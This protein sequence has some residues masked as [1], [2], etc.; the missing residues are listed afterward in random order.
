MTCPQRRDGYRDAPAG[1][2]LHV[3]DQACL[4]ID[5]GRVQLAGVGGAERADPVRA[6]RRLG[7]GAQGDPGRF[8]AVVRERAA[9]GAQR[10]GKEPVD[11]DREGIQGDVQQRAPGA[12]R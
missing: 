1:E 3:L 10:I 5:I 11:A 9:G 8:R 12:P 6:G 2:R 4:L 7:P